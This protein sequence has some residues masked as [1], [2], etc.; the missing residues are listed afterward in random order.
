M[1]KPQRALLMQCLAESR[2]IYNEMLEMVKAQY[3]EKG[4]FPSKYDLEMALKGRSKHVP[5]T[6]IQCLADR[7]TKAL[8]RFLACK[9]LGLPCGFFHQ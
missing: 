8:K 4:T 6:T 7:L 1:N 5:A 3:E 9:E 2:L